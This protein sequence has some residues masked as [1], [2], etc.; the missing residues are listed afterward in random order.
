MAKDS[1]GKF[2]TIDNRVRF[3]GKEFTIKD[4]HL[5]EGRYGTARIEFTEEVTHTKELPDEISVDLIQ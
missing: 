3:R 1:T 4:F 2:I 5:N